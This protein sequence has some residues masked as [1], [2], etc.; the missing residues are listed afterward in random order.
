M[1]AYTRLSSGYTD[2]TPVTGSVDPADDSVLIYVS[3]SGGNDANDGLTEGNAVATIAKGSSLMRSGKPDHLLLKRG[4][5]FAEN[6]GIGSG[7][8]ATAPCVVRPY[9]TGARPIIQGEMRAQGLTSRDYA[10]VSGI[11][12]NNALNLTDQFC[13]TLLAPCQS[14]LFEDLKISGYGGGFNIDLGVPKNDVQIRYCVVTNNSPAQMPSGGH[15]Q[16]IYAADINDLLIEENVFHQNGHSGTRTDATIF[17]HNLYLREDI[18]GCIVRNNIISDGASH[19]LS[20]NPPATIEGNLIVKAP[21]GVFARSNGSIVRNNAI[22]ESVD[23]DASTPRGYGVIIG[24]QWLWDFSPATV[25]SNLIAN[26]NATGN[27][28][29]M[30]VQGINN[31]GS[32]PL[33]VTFDSNVVVNWGSTSLQARGTPVTALG[34]LTVT[35]NIFDETGASVTMVDILDEITIDASVYTFSGNQYLTTDTTPFLGNATQY[36]LAQWQAGPEPTASVFTDG[37][38]NRGATV[39]DY[40]DSISSGDGF[41]EFI[42]KAILMSRESYDSRYTALPVLNYLRAAHN[43]PLVSI[44]SRPFSVS[45]SLLILET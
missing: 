22:V 40:A 32:S 18:N 17:S 43:M 42:A 1:A 7:A 2:L 28:P 6:I 5:T 29:A 33:E 31:A 39:A 19:G 36:S 35:N 44:S 15:S 34:S 12:F 14:I 23:I 45:G 27:L 38:T 16:A 30:Q 4:D 10:I 37:F 25:S 21:V 24:D 41:N 8:S 20:C 3:S 26:N 11:E 9:G 13:V